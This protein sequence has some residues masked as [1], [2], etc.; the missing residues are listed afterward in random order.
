M[1]FSPLSHSYFYKDDM[2]VLIR[3]SAHPAGGFFYIIGNAIS[4][5]IKTSLSATGQGRH[6]SWYHLILLTAYACQPH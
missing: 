6:I 4:Y 3:A 1:I 2:L 5:Y